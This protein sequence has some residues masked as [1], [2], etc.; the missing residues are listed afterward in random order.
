VVDAGAPHRDHLQG[1]TRGEDRVREVR[2]RAD[3][4]RDGRATD[5]LDELRFLVRSPRRDD[6]D[7]AERAA[8]LV[9]DGALEDRR[10][11]VGD[12]DLRLRHGARQAAVANARCAAA[13]PTP[14]S[15]V[16]PR[17]RSVIS[18]AESVGSTYCGLA[19]MPIVPMRSVLVRIDRKSTRLNSSHVSIS[20]AVFC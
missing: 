19:V 9:R 2:V 13:T 17:S 12:D 4:D 18:S 3:V 10:E 11:V 7:L 1:G 20:Y 8:L 6:L 16:W 15:S 5:A 14:G